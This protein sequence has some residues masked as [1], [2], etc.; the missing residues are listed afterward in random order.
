M[1]SK[2]KLLSERARI[3]LQ[4]KLAIPTATLTIRGTP[5]EV[6][7]A[8]RRLGASDRFGTGVRGI[9]RDFFSGPTS[10][11]LLMI[12]A[13]FE[14]EEDEEFFDP[15]PSLRDKGLDP[16]EEVRSALLS[17]GDAFST[18]GLLHVDSPYLGLALKED[19][20]L[21]FAALSVSDFR[22]QCYLDKDYDSY[23]DDVLDEA[24]GHQ[25]Q[26]M[27]LE[28]FYW[29]RKRQHIREL[30]SQDFLESGLICYFKDLFVHPAA[31]G[32][33]LG[34][35]LMAHALS[36]PASYFAETLSMLVCFP[37]REGAARDPGDDPEDPCPSETLA[38]VNRLVRM[39]EKLGFRKLKGFRPGDPCSAFMLHHNQWGT[40]WGDG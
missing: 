13:N 37:S 35:R 24:V 18:F 4:K 10:E 6:P 2:P 9:T 36:D 39:Y 38:G 30:L 29:L 14:E 8:Y 40:P 28:A 31:R 1:L 3:A 5:V 15:Y 34:T 12:V 19:K 7:I 16:V 23:V 33:G 17:E 20:G 25:G 26:G 11:Q 27:V 32:Q 21:T 22:L